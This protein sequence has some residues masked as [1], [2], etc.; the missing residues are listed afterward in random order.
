M[1]M[2]R[3]LLIHLAL[4]IT[5]AVIAFAAHVERGSGVCSVGGCSA[6]FESSYSTLLGIPLEIWAIAWFASIALVPAISIIHGAWTGAA[7]RIMTILVLLGVAAVPPLIYVELLILRT[8]CMYCTAMHALIIAV[9][10]TWFL[11]GRK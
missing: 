6:V 2:G 4:S 7:R 11:M 9:A 3:W 10:F 5:G 8:V 1:Y